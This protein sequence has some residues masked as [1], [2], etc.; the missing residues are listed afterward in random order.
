MEEEVKKPT[1][2]ELETKIKKAQKVLQEAVDNFASDRKRTK[3][4]ETVRQVISDLE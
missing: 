3:L 1:T 4:A 2:K